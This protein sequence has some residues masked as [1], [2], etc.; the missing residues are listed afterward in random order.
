MDKYGSFLKDINLNM[1]LYSRHYFVLNIKLFSFH[2]KLDVFRSWRLR[3]LWLTLIQILEKLRTLGMI[4][5]TSVID[6]MII[7]I[8]VSRNISRVCVKKKANCIFLIKQ[9]WNVKPLAMQSLSKPGQEQIWFKTRIIDEY[10]ET[11]NHDGKW[12]LWFDLIKN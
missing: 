1:Y 9:D 10:V 5:N 2:T 3:Q 4:I 7:A 8:V 6:C 12:W 11:Y